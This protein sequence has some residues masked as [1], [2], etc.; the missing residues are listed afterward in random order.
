M[1]TE[2]QNPETGMLLVTLSTIESAA[3]D[4]D[5]AERYARRAVDFERS[6]KVTFNGNG[7]LA[8]RQLAEVLLARGDCSAAE[9]SLQDQLASLSKVYPPG[10]ASVLLVKSLLGGSLICLGRLEEAEAVLHGVGPN[11]SGFEFL[12]ERERRALFDRL[13][14]LYEGLGDSEEAAH[15]H[16]LA[17]L[18]DRN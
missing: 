4:L 3:G 2:P 18:R 11:A 14:R 6:A 8:D 16:Q 7:I 15:F 5:A 1:A 12:D 10:H 9:R 17:Q 13:S